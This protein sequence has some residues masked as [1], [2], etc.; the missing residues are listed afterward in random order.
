MQSLP[1]RERGLKLVRASNFLPVLRV[2][3]HAGAWIEMYKRIAY[4]STAFV[5]PH[6]GAWIEINIW[7]ISSCVMWSLPTRERGLKYV[8]H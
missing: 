4:I 8:K 3:P 5:A 2:A 6:A 1:T 7:S